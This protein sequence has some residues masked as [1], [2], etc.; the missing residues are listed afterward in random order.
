MDEFDPEVADKEYDDR[1]DSAVKAF[2]ADIVTAAKE[3]NFDLDI[4][5]DFSLCFDTR[6]IKWAN[7]A[8]ITSELGIVIVF[9][10]FKKQSAAAAIVNMGKINAM[11]KEG[12]S[13]EEID[14]APIYG[15]L[16]PKSS[17]HA[18]DFGYYLSNKINSPKP[19][20]E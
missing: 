4:D 7:S 20:H 19:N 15:T 17:S 12:F 16:L 8:V 2:A 6:E 3:S 13:E 9:P 1:T 14:Q 18:K 10:N 5:V 11:E